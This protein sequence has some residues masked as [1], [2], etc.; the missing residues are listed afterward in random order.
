MK[1]NV[2]PRASELIA[3]LQGRLSERRAAEESDAAPRLAAE[4]VLRSFLGHPDLLTDE[5]LAADPLNYRQH[6]IH[7]E[8]D[9]SFSVVALVWLPGQQTPIHD[10]ASWCVVGVYLGEEK[11]E[12]FRLA[13]DREGSHLV[14][15]SNGTNAEGSVTSVAPPGD[16]HLV[17]NG[18]MEKVVSIHIYGV[19]VTERG[20]SIRQCYDLPIRA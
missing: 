1:S 12:R 3:A 19:D 2:T 9:G 5:Q 16:I 18:T 7:A 17:R 11:E 4:E 6:V 14:R 10:H 15:I 13:A 8:P 20:S